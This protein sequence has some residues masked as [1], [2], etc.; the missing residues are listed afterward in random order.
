[1][2]L[3]KCKPIKIEWQGGLI[4]S[5]EQAVVLKKNNKTAKIEEESPKKIIGL[6]S[7]RFEKKGRAGSPVLILFN[8]SDK[9][10]KNGASLKMLCS[11]LKIKLACGGTV[12]NGE[13]V[14]MHR[15]LE[16]L[17]NVLKVNF[18]INSR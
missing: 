15:D 1:M 11:N 14:L 7:I 17:K 5:D 13:I 12:E 18:D 8:F 2:T 10:A 3:K 4:S 16:K 9:E 6:V